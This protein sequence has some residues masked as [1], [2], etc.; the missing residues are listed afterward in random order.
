M[1]LTQSQLEAHPAW[2]RFSGEATR[3]PPLNGW[4]AVPLVGRDGGNLGLV[5]LSDKYQGEFTEAD[6]AILVQLAQIAAV[7]EQLR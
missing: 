2:R 3:H 4:L 6:E 5:Q 7:A 1:R